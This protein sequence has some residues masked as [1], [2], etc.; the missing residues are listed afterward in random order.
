MIFFLGFSAKSQ[1]SIQFPTERA[2]F[3]RALNNQGDIYISG[4][5][6]QSVD[7]VEAR[8]LEYKDDSLLVLQDWTAIENNSRIGSFTGKLTVKG[9][10][11][12]LEVRSIVDEQEID[13]ATLS[14]VGVGEVFII[15]GQSNAQ[16]V[17][18]YGGTGAKDDRVNTADFLNQNFSKE[19]NTNLVFS[20][21]NDNANIGPIGLTPWCWGQIGDS[22]A[23]R[24]DVPIMFF[25]TALTRTLS[26]NW[27]QSSIGQPT[28][29]AIFQG[30]FQPGFPYQYL[31]TTMKHYASLFGI[32]AVLWHQGET[33]TY[34]GVPVEDE[35]FGYYKGVIDN[36][37][38]DF[39]HNMA[40]MFSRVSYS[41]G[42]TSQV[43]LNSH[44][45]II[46]EPNFNIYEGPSTDALMIPR[47]DGVH[48]GNTAAVK[49][50]EQLA[51][52]W[53]DKLNTNFFDVCEPI[54]LNPLV[55]LDVDCFQDNQA[56]VSV[57]EN[58][59]IY[60]WSDGGGGNE[61]FL[62]SGAVSADLINDVG[63]FKIGTAVNIEAVVFEQPITFS[64]KTFIC[65]E[66]TLVLSS[67]TR[68][69]DIV[70][71]NDSLTAAIEIADGGTFSYQAK[72]AIG[73]EYESEILTIEDIPLPDFAQNLNLTING[74]IAVGDTIVGFCEGISLAVEANLGFDSYFWSDSSDLQNRLLDNT[75][76][77]SYYG[78]YSPGCI[79]KTSPSLSVVKY[80][81]PAKPVIYSE[82]IFDLGV[83]NEGDYD[84]FLWEKDGVTLS[85][86]KAIIKTLESGAYALSVFRT[87]EDGTICTSEWSD[88]YQKDLINVDMNVAYPNPAENF[89][90]LES[91]EIQTNVKVSLYDEMGKSVNPILFL[92]LWE[93]RISIPV[94]Q[95]EGGVYILV[96][97]SDQSLLRK[98]IVIP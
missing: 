62:T 81:K 52:A 50:L 32:R 65:D 24:L 68:F 83:A 41:D 10:W 48:F 20:Q 98:K 15:S 78:S 26:S 19:P 25:N 97:E 9:G 43:V 16:G 14:K 18:G 17:P 57:P 61:R 73:C 55:E 64:A 58:Y 84:G 39:G 69:T 63:N 92:P 28:K 56:R 79:S 13:V 38:T 88:V 21:L 33:D 85:Q 54:L 96:L 93:T 86:T 31:K 53:L 35:I 36:I 76:T 67:D 30:Y 11:Y 49:G 87:Y 40:W 1:I 91:P 51:E 66:E 8:L 7:R 80:D 94:T 44:D 77:V 70:W 95:L 12:Q 75:T 23:K 74:A 47:Y 46:N 2:V 82:A 6:G 3:Q 60:K 4:S 37:R 72:N 5:I 45:R 42:R 89:I 59:S 22:L 71:N 27:Y 90:Y 34:P 29:D